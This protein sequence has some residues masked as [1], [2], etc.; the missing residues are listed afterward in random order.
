MFICC[1][2][3]FIELFLVRKNFARMKDACSLRKK[4]KLKTRLVKTS[5]KDCC[6]RPFM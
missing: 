2:F 6:R 5:L 1:G 3:D 4:K